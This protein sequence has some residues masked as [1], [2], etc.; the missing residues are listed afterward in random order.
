MSTIT[1]SCLVVSEN[2]YENTFA[3]EIDT[4]KLVSFFRDAIKKKNTQVFVNVDV[5]DLKLWKVDISFEE[6][7]KKLE[8]VNTKINN[9]IKEHLSGEELSPFLKIRKHFPFQPADEHI[10]I[11]VQRPVETKEVHCIAIYS[12]DSYIDLFRFD[13]ELSDTANY[14]KILEHILENIAMKYKTCIHIT[15]ANEATRREFISFVL[16]SIASC[17]DG[18]VKVYPEYELSE[19]YGKGPV[20]WV[21]K[22]GDTIIVITKAKREDINQDVDQNAI[23]LQVSSQHNKKKCIYNKALREDVMYDIILTG[24]DW[25]IIKLVTTGECN[26]NDNENVEQNVHARANIYSGSKTLVLVNASYNAPSLCFE[27]VKFE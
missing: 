24:V 3:V 13:E 6:K 12:P 21:I 7:N 22:I 5:K 20:D 10:Y 16:H 1:L 2:P 19:S 11:I 14:E 25:V 8:L 18:E 26:D 9:I 27:G 4:M 23:Q 17:Y 15:S